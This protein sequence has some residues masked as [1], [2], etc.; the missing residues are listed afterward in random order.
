MRY[1]S[2]QKP[3]EL[4]HLSKINQRHRIK[5]HTFLTRESPIKKAQRFAECLAQPDV[6][7]KT[8]VAKIFN[9]HPSV[10]TQHLKLLTLPERIITFLL[11]HDDDPAIRRYFTEK[12]LRPLTFVHDSETIWHFMLMMK[13]VKKHL[14][15]YFQ[16][17]Q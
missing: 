7:T 16:V 12:R 3:P 8:Q 2:G 9:T 14:S 11:E 17:V 15:D 10:V 13:K 4:T 1:I 6:Q 5:H